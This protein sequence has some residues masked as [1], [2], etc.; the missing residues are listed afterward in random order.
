MG[1]PLIYCH[2]SK[3]FAV[4]PRPAHL[5]GD[6]EYISSDAVFGVKTSLVAPFEPSDDVDAKWKSPFDFVLAKA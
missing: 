4:S 1:K 5:G 2:L 3:Y 6:D